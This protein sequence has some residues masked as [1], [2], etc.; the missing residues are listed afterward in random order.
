M[1]SQSAN[2]IQSFSG[3]Y[4]KLCLANFVVRFRGRQATSTFWAKPSSGKSL[5]AGTDIKVLYVH[6]LIEIELN[7]RHQPFREIC[8]AVPCHCAS[9]SKYW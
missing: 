5:A 3:L 2:A 1:H 4:L 8:V 6:C 7:Q 9:A